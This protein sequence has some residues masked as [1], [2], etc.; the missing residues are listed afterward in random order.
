[1]R[2]QPAVQLAK[3]RPVGKLTEAEGFIAFPK[4]RKS[5]SLPIRLMYRT[6]RNETSLGKPVIAPESPAKAKMSSRLVPAALTFALL[7]LISRVVGG[8]V[9]GS[10]RNR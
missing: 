8:G 2:T 5:V 3:D 9:P 10:E 7:V 6:E 4:L 1:M